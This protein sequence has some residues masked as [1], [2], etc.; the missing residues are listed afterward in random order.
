MARKPLDIDFYAKALFVT[1]IVPY[2]IYYMVFVMP[3]DF[4]G[5]LISLLFL[6][7]IEYT[8][9]QMTVREYREAMGKR[10][11][12]KPKKKKPKG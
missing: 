10:S 11:Y 4:L 6:G 12:A 9:V 5:K 3:T 1:I 7:L 2:A 8:F